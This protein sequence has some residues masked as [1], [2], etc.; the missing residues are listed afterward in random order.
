MK[1]LK[2]I[3]LLSFLSCLLPSCDFLGVDDYFSDEI[4]IDS[5]FASKRNAEAYLWGITSY[6]RDEGRLIVDN[7]VQR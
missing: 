1:Y 7:D 5:V 2:T 4:K 6:L 3:L